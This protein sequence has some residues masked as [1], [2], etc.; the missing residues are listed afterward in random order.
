M[1]KKR[2]KICSVLFDR[3]KKGKE[4]LEERYKYDDKNHFLVNLLSIVIRKKTTSM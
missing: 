3:A 1:Q 4:L 2:E